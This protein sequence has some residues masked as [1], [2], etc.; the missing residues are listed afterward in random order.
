MHHGF[1]NLFGRSAPERLAALK[2][3]PSASKTVPRPKPA[4]RKPP[5]APP[6]TVRDDRLD[7]EKLED[8]LDEGLEE[9]EGEGELEEGPSVL[10]ILGAAALALHQAQ[11][12]EPS[13]R[14]QLL[15]EY[16]DLRDSGLTDEWAQAELRRK[17]KRVV[18]QS[19][20]E[21]IGRLY[22]ELESRGSVGL[23][24]PALV[25]ALVAQSLEQR[26]MLPA[27]AGPAGMVPLV[28][29][30]GYEHRVQHV[31]RSDMLPHGS[32]TRG[33]HTEAVRYES[34]MRG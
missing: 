14:A 32:R 27:P 11:G 4:K 31:A 2:V 16:R 6:R 1:N 34:M 19:Q 28:A 9:G 18:P 23:D 10:G 30:L 21:R 26:K 5:D 8:D 12:L 25:R 20:Q 15:Q 7:E 22:S 13:P 3:R 24:L 29:P 33:M 17:P